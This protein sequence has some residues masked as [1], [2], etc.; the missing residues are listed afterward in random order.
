MATIER[1]PLPRIPAAEFLKH[2]SP[3]R[4]PDVIAFALEAGVEGLILAQCNDF[5]SVAMGE[6]AAY[7]Y[8]TGKTLHP[9]SV[10]EGYITGGMA[11]Q[12]KSL[13]GYCPWEDFAALAT[14]PAS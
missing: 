7:Q 8:G 13:I 2:F 12:R 5:C 14:A 11:W 6:V 9:D 1:R 3:Y 10:H 4:D